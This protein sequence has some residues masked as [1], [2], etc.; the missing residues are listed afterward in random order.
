VID[1]VCAIHDMQG[2]RYLQCIK[3]ELII[4]LNA[5][6][7]NPCKR[8]RKTGEIWVKIKIPKFI[9]ITDE[10]TSTGVIQVSKN[11]SVRTVI[12]ANGIS[13]D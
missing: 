3:M 2:L 13:R 5:L 8:E 11:K 10:R 6:L 7:N 1:C 4:G 12:S 9:R